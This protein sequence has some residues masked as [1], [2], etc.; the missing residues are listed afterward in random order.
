[1]ADAAGG[2]A[3]K[4]AV[5][6]GASSP[7][8]AAAARALARE[9]VNLA[10]GGRDRQALEAL[11]GEVET[12]GG[13]AIIVG[14]HL[15]KRHHPAHLVEAAV[16][17]FGGL[18][19]LVFM[20]RASAPPLADLDVE[21]WER[22]VDVNLKGFLYCL[23]AALP[24]MCEG[25]GGRVVVLHAGERPEVPDPLGRA[26]RLAVG[27]VLEDLCRELPSEDFLA[28]EVVADRP[29]LANPEGCA[30]A[31]IHALQTSEYPSVGLRTYR[32][33]TT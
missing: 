18:D 1:V 2:L 31:V 16:E 13:R 25:G 17:Q 24:A 7:Y 11:H 6:L 32:V 28:A 30:E 33:P 14:T 21:A 5:L 27:S 8:A 9:G 22:S 19:F 10:L 26:C 3:G 20:A 12:L 23:A 4:T 29:G 15:A